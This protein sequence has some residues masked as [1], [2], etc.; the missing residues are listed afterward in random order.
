M[1]Y[2]MNYERLINEIK[3]PFYVY[4]IDILTDRI[5]YLNNK[6]PNIG[7]VYAVKA[8]SF[9][10]KELDNLVER[11]EICSFGEFEI[12]DRLNVNDNKMVISG[13]NK[14]PSEIEYLIQ[15]KAILKYTV[16]SVNQYNLLLNLAEKYKKQI[17][18]LIRLTSNNQFGVTVDEALDII[19]NNNNQYVEI[20]GIEYF[21]GTQKHSI[22]KIAREVDFLLDFIDKVKEELGF[23]IKEVEYGLGLPVFY[24]QDEEFNEDEYLSEVN[25]E[26]TRFGNKKLTIE[27]GRSIAASCGYYF[28]SVVDLKENRFGKNVI[29]DGGMNHL[30]YYGQTMAMRHPYFDLYPK[31]D[32]ELVNYNLYGSLCTVNDIVVK[33]IDVPKLEL[34]DTFIF[35]NVGAYSSTEG[36]SLFLSRNLPKIVLH[37][38]GL[39]FIIVREDLK[40]SEIN[41]PKY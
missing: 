22:K 16:E 28:T 32:K 4:D 10:V 25:N 31:R 2:N 5:K 40:T 29:L 36:I 27:L 21:S 20:D 8:N 18:L 12:C 15:N 38:N 34:N 35:K 11:F 19:K 13:V 9:I 1:E 26:L 6:F 41:F 24:F 3:T 33:S 37:K 30:V 7:L 39:D 17:S 23:D 14:T